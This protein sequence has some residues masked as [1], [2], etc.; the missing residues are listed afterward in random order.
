MPRIHARQVHQSN[1]PADSPET[2]YGQTIIIPFLDY[3]LV[4]MEER[5]GGTHQKIINSISFSWWL[6]QCLWMWPTFSSFK[7]GIQTMENKVCFFRI[8]IT[9]KISPR[10]SSSLWWKDSFPH[11]KQLLL[12]ARTLLVPVC[13][14][15]RSNSQPKLLRDWLHQKTGSLVL[16]WWR[17]IVR[18]L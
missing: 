12:I 18:K 13:E 5:F 11:I 9:A 15:E 10:S 2:S 17:F 7:F 4:E 6:R 3:I 1:I 14:N 8:R 16:Q